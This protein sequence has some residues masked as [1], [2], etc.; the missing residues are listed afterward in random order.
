[1][2]RDLL[3]KRAPRDLI[4]GPKHPEFEPANVPGGVPGYN[5][6]TGMVERSKAASA[7]HG[8][9]DTATAGFGDEATAALIAPFSEKDY[10][11]IR[12]EIRA[13]QEG[14][15][16][17]NP[18]SYL[19]GQV[20]GGVAQA[21][22]LG[23]TGASLGANAARAGHGLGRIAAG[24]AVD[25]AVVGLLQGAGSGEDVEERAKRAMLGGA[26]GLAAGGVAPYAVAG[27]SRVGGALA[28]PLMA[29]LRPESYADNA[30]A[31]GLRRSGT[32]MDEIADA[33][34]SARVDGQDVFTVADAMGNAGQR[35]LSTAARNPHE[36]RQA[37]VE[38]LEA[39]QAGQ[40]RRIAGFLEDGFGSPQ[41]AAQ[42][43]TAT[44]A[45]RSTAGN[46]NYGAA[47]AAA[48]AVD[49]T[50]AIQAID[51]VIQPGVT[52]LVGAGADDTGVYATLNRARG[53]LTNGQ[54]QVSDFDRAL[55][56]KQEM[57]AIIERGGVAAARLRPARDALD[58][59][60]AQSSAPYATARDTYRQQSLALEAVDT[61]RNAARRGRVEDTIPAFGSMSPEQQAGFRAGYVDP[62]VES[63]QGAAT[64]VN[65]A[66]PLI[67]DATAAEFPAFATPGR[68]DELSRRIAREQTMFE[69]RNAATGGSRTADNLSDASDMANFD[70]SIMQNLLQGRPLQAIISAVGRGAN[71]AR[72]LPPSVLE[73]VSRALMETNPDAAR[74]LLEVA[75]QRGASSAS[76]RAIAGAMI[77]NLAGSGAGRF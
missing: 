76:R 56:A 62:L 33:L 43:E 25:G 27:V 30:M 47:R 11:Q 54:S 41:T 18:K 36:G 49:T 57:D 4:G 45:L 61:G 74:Q 12:D 23:G 51:E 35:M 8:F 39:R 69:T 16:A 60:L 5:P 48:G 7:A 66:R 52:P 70:P 59:A 77:T 22:T 73:R 50:P 55:L 20:A 3:A 67:N 53:W 44:R 9:S 34:T 28:A 63:T 26:A 37:L 24:S 14:A 1:M 65:K 15:R 2:P 10:G 75:S 19:A 13:M 32:S 64:G 68:G 71:E 38:A 29:R 31:E 58:D 72:G 17:D 21:A 6:E 42:T 40:G 46:A